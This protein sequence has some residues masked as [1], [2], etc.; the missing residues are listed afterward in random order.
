MTNNPVGDYYFPLL[1]VYAKWC[2]EIATITGDDAGT[3]MYH[4]TFF[5]WSSD[6]S[7][8]VLIG[9]TIGSNDGQEIGFRGNLRK[10]IQQSRQ[11][12]LEQLGYR[13]PE[14][15]EKGSTNFG[16]CA[17]SDLFIWLKQCVDI[18]NHNQYLNANFKIQKQDTLIILSSSQRICSQCQISR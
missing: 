7:T 5:P 15:N 10:S 3:F 14:L 9:S 6:G 18:H 17:E 13:P 11:K 2:N 8:R 1:S 4:I 12:E 16:S